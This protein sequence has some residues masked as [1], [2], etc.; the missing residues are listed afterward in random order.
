MPVRGIG[1]GVEMIRSNLPSLKSGTDLLKI[2]GSLQGGNIEKKRSQFVSVE[3]PMA[4]F[5]VLMGNMSSIG[6]LNKKTSGEGIL[7]LQKGLHSM[8]GRTDGK[9]GIHRSDREVIANF[10][11]GCGFNEK[12]IEKIVYSIRDDSGSQ[13]VKN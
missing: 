1:Y 9:A 6:K 4:F 10:L 2:S 3:G 13:N 5:N 7:S 12:E 8:E 11:K